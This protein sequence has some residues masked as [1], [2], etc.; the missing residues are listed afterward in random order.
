M[1]YTVLLVF[2]FLSIT[3]FAQEDISIPSGE[4]D[5]A[6][7]KKMQKLK[8]GIPDSIKVTIKDY[9]FISYARDTTY[10][11][12]TLTIQK[13]YR[14]NYLRKDNFEL[15]S[16]SNIG[17]T[18]N[19]LG[20]NFENDFG[21]PGIGATAKHYNYKEKEDVY[22]YNVP[23]PTS[24]LFFKTTLER[25]Q[26][27]DALLTF[28]T[29]RRLNFSLRYKGFRS[30]GKFLTNQMES[31]NFIAT[32]N[33]ETKNKRYN[34][35]THIASQII[36][37]N[38]NGGLTKGEEQFETGDPDFSDRRR[39]DVAFG[40]VENKIL[41][42]RYF[43]DHQY[44]LIQS[45]VDSLKKA[46]TTLSVG[47][48][49]NYETKYYQ[50]QQTSKNPFFGDETFISEINDK[51]HLKTTYN[52]VNVALRNNIL[53]EL[54]GFV[55]AYNYSYFFKSILVSDT[56]EIQ[57][58]L[59]G[60]E[61]GFGATYKKQIGGF[62][63]EGKAKYNL[64][65]T[66]KGNLIKASA[67]YEFNENTKVKFTLRSS[68]RMPNFN[69]L[70]YQS[71]YANYNWQNT[72]TYE[73]QKVSSLQ[74]SLESKLLGNLSAKYTTL[75]NYTYFASTATTEQIENNQESAFV[76]PFQENKSINY[77]KVKYGKE[78]KVGNFALNNT[79]MYQNVSQQNNVLNLPQFVTRNTLYF[80]KRVFKNA[81]YLQT[82]VTAK[83]FTSYYM[84]AYN[85]LLGEFYSQNQKKLGGFPMLDFFINAK[86]QQTRIYLK[87]EHFNSSF[88]GNKHYAAPNYPYRDFVV[89]FGLV[90]NF[91]S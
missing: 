90:W 1:R 42:K 23:T 32:L 30:L 27:L 6:F 39:I 81:M 62:A 70:L 83:Y 55:D 58:Q 41:G 91:F 56:G 17:H 10:L 40:D 26:L 86:I 36:S 7:E 75:D 29:S 34:F 74:F 13:E 35:R 51:S 76:R 82:G 44:K 43:F 46:F 38:E 60:Q 85:P 87:A 31:G 49:F 78:F 67:A 73:S 47:H 14:Y 50:F 24:D 48:Q 64:S 80:S 21:Y 16:F 25:G 65:G 33:Y 71:N 69:Y 15:I 54:K 37:G 2:S 77:I 53:G 19:K 8:A 28:N 89:R 12:T 4:K 88:S 72:A 45:K 18:Y 84:N 3:L 22:Y 5:A 63:V 11:D 57:N 61:I 68:A 79:V 66:L 9:K 20:V 52:Q 59:N